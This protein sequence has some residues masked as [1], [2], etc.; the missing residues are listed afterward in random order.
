MV[1]PSS[2]KLKDL[3]LASSLPFATNAFDVYPFSFSL[4]TSMNFKLFQF[5]YARVVL[6][7][8]QLDLVTRISISQTAC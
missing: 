1:S 2:S 7:V 5:N 4:E 3:S 8:V 6:L